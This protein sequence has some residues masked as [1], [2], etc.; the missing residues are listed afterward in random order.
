MTLKDRRSFPEAADGRP[1]TPM[2]V[3]LWVAGC[4]LDT[5]RFVA[6]HLAFNSIAMIR[7]NDDGTVS[8]IGAEE[9]QPTTPTQGDTQ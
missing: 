1:S 6:N 3:E 8:Y 7:H 4:D 2:A 5:A 9:W